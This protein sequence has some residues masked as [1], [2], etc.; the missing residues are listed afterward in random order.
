MGAKLKTASIQ[1]KYTMLSIYTLFVPKYLSFF[2]FI[3][4]YFLVVLYY[5][6]AHVY[7]LY[8]SIVNAHIN[9]FATKYVFIR[10]LFGLRL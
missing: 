2:Y 5:D 6:F 10:D 8:Y 3:Q 9:S 1:V 7:Y 4:T